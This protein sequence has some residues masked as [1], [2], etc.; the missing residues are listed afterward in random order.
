MYVSL[1]GWSDWIGRRELMEVR[2]EDID[3]LKVVSRIRNGTKG[4]FMDLLEVREKQSEYRALNMSQKRFRRPIS[5]SQNTET[6][7][8]GKRPSRAATNHRPLFFSTG[9]PI[10]R[11]QPTLHRHASPQSRRNQVHHCHHRLKHDDDDGHH[12]PTNRVGCLDCRAGTGFSRGNSR[13]CK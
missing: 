9:H 7:I 4:T 12:K 8:D 6:S 11:W 1:T 5:P 3:D 10:L 2:E 13:V